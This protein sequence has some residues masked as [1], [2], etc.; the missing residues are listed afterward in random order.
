MS[1]RLPS[2]GG[3]LLA[4]LALCPSRA[5]AVAPPPGLSPCWD[6]LASPDAAPAYAALCRLADHPRQAV[7]L[8]RSRLRPI[9]APAARRIA[10]LIAELDSDSYATRQ[11]AAEDL[12]RLGELAGAALLAAREDR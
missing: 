3:L 5:P 11:K 10:R 4:A 9:P 1:A 2:L 7:P 8:L 12:E 6:E